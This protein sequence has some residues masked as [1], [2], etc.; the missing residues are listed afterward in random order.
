MQPSVIFVLGPPGSGKGTQCELLTQ[1]YKIYHLS[2]GELLRQ[3]K[4]SSSD[5]GKKIEYYMK[6]GLIVPVN[7]TIGLIEKEMNRI[8][9]S[10]TFLIDGF[11]RNLENLHGWNDIMSDKVNVQCVL[12]FNIHENVIE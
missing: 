7:V 10:N 12:W 1:K 11:P 2:A 5:V 9:K 6:E 8:G 3:E 4:D